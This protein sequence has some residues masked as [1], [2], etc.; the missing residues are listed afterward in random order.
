MHKWKS[1]GAAVGGVGTGKPEK[2]G[3]TETEDGEASV[4]RQLTMPRLHHLLRLH[5]HH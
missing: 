1:D 3:C 2:T 4:A 5:T